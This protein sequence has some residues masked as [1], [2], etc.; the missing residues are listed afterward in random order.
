MLD[1]ELDVGL[2]AD[3][4]YYAHAMNAQVGDNPQR[5]VGGALDV[6]FGAHM[7]L[8]YRLP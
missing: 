5:L 3:L 6:H 2:G 1:D 8:T 7:M 4:R